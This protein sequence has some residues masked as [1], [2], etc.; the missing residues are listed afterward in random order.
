VA[1][2]LYDESPPAIY[3]YGKRGIAEQLNLFDPFHDAP[4]EEGAPML[5]EQS[6]Y[7]RDRRLR[8]MCLQA[9]GQTCLVC[10]FDAVSS[11]GAEAL[12]VIEVHHLQPLSDVGEAHTVD[13]LRDL[14]PVCPNCHAVIHRRTPSFTTE[15]VRAMLEASRN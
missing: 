1:D 12:G 6:V 15:E 7:E 11:Y 13:P 14:I 9:R 3:Y 2:T 5:V 4:A 10:G 8:E